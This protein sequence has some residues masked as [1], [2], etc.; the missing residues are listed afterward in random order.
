VGVAEESITAAESVDAISR[1][2][3]KS[4]N[5]EKDPFG[6]VHNLMAEHV[7]L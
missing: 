2:E 7:L 3:N 5:E 4:L 1:K 6:R